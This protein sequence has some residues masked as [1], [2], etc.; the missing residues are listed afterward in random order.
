MID[1]GSSL[2]VPVLAVPISV[3]HVFYALLLGFKRSRY[4][5]KKVKY[6]KVVKRPGCVLPTYRVWLRHHRNYCVH[7]A[8]ILC[9]CKMFNILE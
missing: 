7:G 1:A 8:C 9:M 6:N 3:P 5:N 2:A 4:S